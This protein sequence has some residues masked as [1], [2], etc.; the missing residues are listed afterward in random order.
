M[1]HRFLCEAGQIRT[2]LFNHNN[3]EIESLGG[4]QE[5]VWSLHSGA[6]LRMMKLACG[7]RCE[8]E[9][10]LDW[11]YQNILVVALKNHQL[12]LS[13]Q[14]K[15]HPNVFVLEETKHSKHHVVKV[16]AGQ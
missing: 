1:T 5:V 12:K 9:V 11:T 14:T 10:E 13:H 4:G 3:I 16:V 7:G 2:K 15:K 8:A 6:V